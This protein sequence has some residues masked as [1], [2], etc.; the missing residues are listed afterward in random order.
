MAGFPLPAWLK[1]RRLSFRVLLAIFVLSLLVTLVSAG[2][3][4]YADYRRDLNA[5]QDRFVE[6]EAGFSSSLASS[7]W[8]LDRSQLALQLRGILQLP[9]V[10][11]VSLRG[12]V[13]M[14]LG[15]ESEYPS[16]REHRFS[17]VHEGRGGESF[18]VGEVVVTASLAGIHER[19]R[20]RALVILSTQAVEIFAISLFILAIIHVLVTRHL[21]TLADFA[22]RLRLDHLAQPAVLSRR[23]TGLFRP[24]ELDE[25]VSALNDMRRSL[26]V[27]IRERE[28]VEHERRRLAEALRQ[29][30]AGIVILDDDGYGVFANPRFLEISGCEEDDFVGHR[31][32]QRGGWFAERVALAPGGDDP[33]RTVRDRGEWQGELRLRRPDGHYRWGY[34]SV[35]AVHVGEVRYYVVLVEDITRLKD[36]EEQIAF[37]AHFDTLTEL[38]NRVL[39]YER[40]SKAIHAGETTGLIFLDLVDFKY[41]NETLGHE[42]GDQVLVEVASRLGEGVAEEWTLARFGS[43]EFLVVIPE[44][45][46]VGALRNVV[47]NLL[48]RLREPFE[49]EGQQVFVTASAGVAVTPGA[50]ASARE[51]IQAADTALYVA[52]A[53]RVK[54]WRFYDPS[55]T[56]ETHRRLTMEAELRQALATGQFVVHYQPILTLA[57]GALA[58]FE[59]LLRWD[60]PER[61]L[62]LPEEFVD[63]AEENGLIVPIGE[64]AL[65]R[66]A[67]DLAELECDGLVGTR[68]GMSVNISPRQLHEKSFDGLVQETLTDHGIAPERLELEITERMLI[69]DRPVTRRNLAELEGMGVR[70]SVD[71][72]G[73]GYSA[74]TYLKRLHV[75]TLKVDKEF[76]AGIPERPDQIQLVRAIVSLAHGLRIEVVAEGI[77]TREQLR[78]M[79]ECGCERAQGHLFLPPMPVEALRAALTDDPNVAS[80]F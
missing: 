30:P 24:D 72:F 35:R 61:G 69:E 14:T 44:V 68:V 64:W 1:Q 9:H 17:L 49:V 22:S 48:R 58:G 33:W 78:F 15:E 54:S 16:R 71:D 37:Q 28:V 23:P 2:I 74:L 18:R 80:S 53:D 13:D 6:A 31:V 60:H 63:Q 59:A 39:A 4:L 26:E 36:A 45:E 43:D 46:N 41:V 42:I 47:E 65:H 75:D 19:L 57:D 20:E 66:A 7:V 8:A 21:Q 56:R 70:L 27:D 76:V 73:T 29:S 52:K 77:E 34:A 67:R 10:E 50:G 79:E 38:P 25:V 40:L 3:Q 51:L 5:L 32:F 11:Q 12:D 62:L 55:M